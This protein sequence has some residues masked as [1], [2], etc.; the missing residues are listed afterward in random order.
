MSRSSPGNV[1]IRLNS[2]SVTARMRR[3]KYPPTS[4]DVMPIAKAML[5]PM[6]AETTLVSMEYRSLAK[7]SRPLLS[8]PS[9]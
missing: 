4:P 8:P 6:S 7:M 5:V 9:R 2:H 1:M 3:P